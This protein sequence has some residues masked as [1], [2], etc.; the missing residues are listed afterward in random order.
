[1]ERKKKTSEEL[2]TNELVLFKKKIFKGQ[3]FFKGLHILRSK[4]WKHICHCSMAMQIHNITGHY[5]HTIFSP[6]EYQTLK[7]VSV[8]TIFLLLMREALRKW[9]SSWD[10]KLW[11][12]KKDPLSLIYFNLLFFFF[13]NTNTAELS[14]HLFVHL[15]ESWLLTEY[16][17]I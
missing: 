5:V 12:L 8:M 3:D 10:L 9:G 17:Y 13:R 11:K 6:W 4:K 16:K 15:L 2:K 1:M 7:Q 14:N